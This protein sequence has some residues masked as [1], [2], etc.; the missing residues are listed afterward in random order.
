MT[1]PL[2]TIIYIIYQVINIAY[3]TKSAPKQKWL[4]PTSINTFIKCPRRYYYIHVARFKKPP[5]IH[6]IRGMTVHKT[7][8]SFYKL[9]IKQCQG[10]DFIDLKLI[11]YNLFKQEWDRKNATFS[12]INLTKTDQDYFFQASLKM[13]YHFVEEYYFNREFE[14]PDPVLEK[15]L[16]DKDLMIRGR[17]DAI[18]ENCGDRSPLIVDFK[19]CKSKII[20]PAYSKQ[21]GIYALLYYNN[22]NIIPDI[23]IH[24]L[25][26]KKG[27]VKLPVSKSFL[28]FIK[29]LVLDIHQRIKSNDI[30][31]YPCVCGWCHKQYG[32]IL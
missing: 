5:N 23:K 2:K 14:L 4:T 19:T 30:S 31:D 20:T 15:T 7:I 13:L 22:F 32:H 10:F 29:G 11:I 16:S 25:N 17:V 3:E 27:L 6:L 28:D 24:F 18:H 9:N 21:M 26:F 8:E 12:K 1:L